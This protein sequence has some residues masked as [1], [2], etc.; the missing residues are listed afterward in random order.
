MLLHALAIL[1]GLGVA[2]FAS[3]PCRHDAVGGAVFAV[4]FVVS[5]VLLGEVRAI[6]PVAIALAIAVPAGLLLW[7]PRYALAAVCGGG[8][9]AG[10]WLMLLRLQGLPL[11]LA[12]LIVVA[13]AA[14]SFIARRRLAHFAPA[15]LLEEALLILCL[16]GVVLAAAPAVDAGWQAARQL[17]ATPVSSAPEFAAPWAVGLAVACLVGGGVFAIWRRR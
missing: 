10:L 17:T 12:V 13:V 11:L 15:H 7:Q 2:V 14:T 8:L 1:C 3:L 4:V 9:A 6:E 16:L 5:A